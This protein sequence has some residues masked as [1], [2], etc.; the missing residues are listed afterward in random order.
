MKTNLMLMAAVAVLVT[1]CQTTGSQQAAETNINPVIT[2][3]SSC[4]QIQQQLAYLDSQISPASGIG[5]SEMGVQ[6]ADA[7]VTHGALYSGALGSV[8][9]LGGALAL[10]R[11]GAH[12]AVADNKADIEKATAERTRLQGMFEGKGCVSAL[13]PEMPAEKKAS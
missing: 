8:P 13:T 5:S 6:V 1:G 3:A 12:A 7:A 10:G 11:L 9:F 4:E 2:A